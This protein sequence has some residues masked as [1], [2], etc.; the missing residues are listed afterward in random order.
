MSTI[1]VSRT[2]HRPSSTSF[3]NESWLSLI[4]LIIFFFLTSRVLERRLT[5]DHFCETDMSLSRMQE[6]FTLWICLHL[7]TQIVFS[8]T[9]T[10]QDPSNNCGCPLCFHG[11]CVCASSKKPQLQSTVTR[12]PDAHL[13]RLHVGKTRSQ[14]EKVRALHLTNVIVDGIDE[15]LP[16]L[17]DLPCIQ[18]HPLLYLQHISHVTHELYRKPIRFCHISVL[19]DEHPVL[20]PPLPHSWCFVLLHDMSCASCAV[21]NRTQMT[22]HCPVSIKK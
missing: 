22:E 19:G 13:I 16:T 15:V 12:R 4:S 11:E 9:S 20:S 1:K 2:T 10:R 14:H 6:K 17:I 7:C 18:D 21:G 5:K 3:C 8:L